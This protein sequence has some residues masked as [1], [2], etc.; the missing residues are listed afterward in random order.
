MAG[1]ESS[2]ATGASRRFALH[3]EELT[4]KPADSR[5]HLHACPKRFGVASC[6]RM[7]FR[8]P[9]SLGDVGPV[10]AW[11]AT[12]PAEDLVQRLVAAAIRDPVLG[13][14]LRCEAAQAA[15]GGLDLAA[16]RESI[17]RLTAV[18]SRVTWE[19][20]GE[21][22]SQVKTAVELLRGAIDR[23]PTVALV[24]LCEFAWWRAERVVME[25]QD[26]ET[27]SA[28]VLADLAGLHRRL[29]EA[30]RPDPEELA[31]RLFHRRLQSGL[32]LFDRVLIEYREL[33]GD[34][35][36][37]RFRELVDSAW[38]ALP[39]EQPGESPRLHRS[40][41]RRMRQELAASAAAP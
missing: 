1:S 13:E 33:L 3:A 34:R 25:V 26:S 27:W 23:A 15:V 21:I 18:D 22:G 41:L 24:E 28:G 2:C 19:D 17:E 37:A 39:R 16:L 6:V 11:L 35:G 32:G 38:R 31:T 8:G 14:S 4:A 9:H 10:R 30:V 29:C 40:E 12:L 36:L 20:A 7:R 5:A